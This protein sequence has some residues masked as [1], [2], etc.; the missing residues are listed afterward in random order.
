MLLA[1]STY[2]AIIGSYATC[3]KINPLV[4]YPAHMHLQVRKGLMNEVEFLG[5]VMWLGPMRL[6]NCELL[7]STSL[8]AVELC[9]STQVSEHFYNNKKH[10][11]GDWLF[12]IQTTIF[13]EVWRKMFWTLLGYSGHKSTHQPRK[14]DFVHQTAFPLRRWGLG[15]TLNLPKAC[16]MPYNNIHHPIKH[17][18]CIPIVTPVSCLD[19]I[20]NSHLCF[21][22]ITWWEMTA[23]IVRFLSFI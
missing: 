23:S 17:I 4:L 16:E 1:E 2:H 12:E 13:E 10:N 8:I 18:H 14:F 11:Q 19:L 3:F 5:L 9:L 22:T 21:K 20:G 15:K 7:Q 6:H